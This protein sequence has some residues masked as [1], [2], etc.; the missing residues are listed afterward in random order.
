MLII[1][2]GIFA[3]DRIPVAELQPCN[4]TAFKLSKDLLQ[5]TKEKKNTKTD[6]ETLI[7]ARLGQG[8][9]RQ[10]VLE[11][12]EARCAVTRI[13]TREVIR[14]S[15]IKPWADSSD[16]ERLDP[17]NGLPLVANLEALFDAGLITFSNSG[18][19]Q[20]SS[21]LPANER[22]KLRLSKLRLAKRP[23]SQTAE[24]LNYHQ[25]NIFQE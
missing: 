5:I 1:P 4:R 9:F 2:D 22:T 3:K 17:C 12:W 8:K 16:E 15:H 18:V 11:L 13:S 21:Q 19:L 24:Y 25:T 20:V 10:A 6:Q 14:A 7:Q 23:P